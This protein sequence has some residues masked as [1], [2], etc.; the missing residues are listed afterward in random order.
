MIDQLHIDWIRATHRISDAVLRRTKLQ[1]RGHEWS[2]L[3]PFHQEKTP[4]FTVNDA[5]GFY[6]CFGCGANGDI[7]R[8][9]Q[10][11]ERVSFPEAVEMIGGGSLPYVDPSLMAKAREEA[12]EEKRQG[13]QDARTFWEEGREIAG[14]PADLYLSRRRIFVRP[15]NLR[16]AR[17]PTW[18][19]PRTGRWNAPRPA[20]MLRA[21]DRF[22]DFAGIQRIFLNEEGGKADM[23]NPKL[24]LG[25]IKA[26]G[27][28][29]RFGKPSC[30]AILTGGPEDGLTLFQSFNQMQTVYV[31][32]GEAN[33]PF[34]QL[35]RLTRRV[36]IA[37][38]ND[39]PGEAAARKT[40]EAM[41]LQGREVINIAPKPQFKDWNDEE[42]G[43]A[44]R[45]AA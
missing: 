19:N 1:K 3:C 42:C 41:R 36:V 44:V 2:G 24:T 7:I 39:V 5:K 45:A 23:D 31:S 15:D 22:G 27:G 35:P 20:L 12:E 32:C 28:A 34:L 11:T 30:E 13:I 33:L 37:R 25:R 16:F 14:T 18:K 8:F 4:S 10:E 21:D 40:S 6:H 43:I 17:I 9:V 38:Q 29:V 26:C